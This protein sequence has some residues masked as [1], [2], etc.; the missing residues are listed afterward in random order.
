VNKA[1]TPRVVERLRPRIETVVDDLLDAVAARGGMDAIAD[2]A[3]PMPVTV[4]AELLGVPAADRVA[5][6]NWSAATVGSL[7]PI[8]SA[9][10]AE[11]AGVAR[12]ELSAYLREVIAQRRAEPEDDLISALVAVHEQ[13][14]TLTEQEL[15]TM[16]RLI[17]LAGHETT[18]N[19]IGNGLLALLRHPEQM[20]QLRERPDLAVSAVEELLRYDAPVQLTGRRATERVELGGQTIEPEQRVVVLLGAAN[21]DPAQFPDPDRLDLE[22]S[23]NRHIAFGQGIHFCLGSPLARMEGQIAV[24]TL[25]ER[26]PNLRLREAPEQLRWRK[27]LFLR[28]LEQLP[29]AC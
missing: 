16:C 4:I 12:T 26:M 6:H 11:R 23:P 21:R 18:V 1:F 7:D 28:G 5:L 14:D 15:V 10:T 27:Q 29:V 20:R 17:L 19:L 8:A 3:F 24:S 25:L 2:F 22:R 9:E 13:G